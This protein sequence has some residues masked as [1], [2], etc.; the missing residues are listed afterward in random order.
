MAATRGPAKLFRDGRVYDIT[1]STRGGEYEK[2][3]GVRRPIQFLNAD[4]T[5]AP[6]EAG[7]YLG[8]PGDA[9]QLFRTGGN[10]DLPDQ[11]RAAGRRSAVAAGPS[12]FH[13]T[14]SR[15]PTRHGLAAFR[16]NYNHR[17]LSPRVSRLRTLGWHRRFP[18]RRL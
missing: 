9:I 15:G 12:E 8:D 2:K 16:P 3:T 14:R 18:A 10:G 5:P 17:M 6:L 11:V 7:P 13:P 1:W 4:G